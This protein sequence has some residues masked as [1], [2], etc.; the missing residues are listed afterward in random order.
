MKPVIHLIVA[1]R[2]NFMKIAPLYHKLKQLNLFDIVFVY[3]GQHYDINMSASFLKDLSLPKP[4][5]NLGIGSRTHA[6]QTG[7]V[8]ISYEKVLIEN[9]P[10]WIV[11]AGDVN[12]TL[13][14]TLTAKKLN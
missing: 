1:A 3:T 4:D 5:I 10:D 11:V 7:Y 9:P 13:A 12:S 8:M 2:P 14:C 6:E